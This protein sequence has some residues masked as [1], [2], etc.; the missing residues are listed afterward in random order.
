MQ[1]HCLGTAGYHPNED[2]H[3]SCYF[4]PESGIVLDAGTGMFRLPALI[5]TPSLDIL[6]SH[7]H[8]D[9]IA[10]LTFLLDIL[11]QHPVQTVRIW[12]EAK[13]LSAIREHLFSE[14][15]FPVQ[16]DVQWCEIDELP[17]FDL[18]DCTVS[19]QRQ[20]HPG[21]SVG[22]RLDFSRRQQSGGVTPERLRLLY[23]TDTT[24]RTDQEMMHWCSEADLMMHECYFPTD[25]SQWAIR[26]GHSWTDRVAEIAAATRP[27]LLLLTHVNPLDPD[28][29]ALRRQVE[30]ALHADPIPTR[31]AEDRMKL[32]FG[33]GNG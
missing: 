9:H 24:G 10:G 23:L 19:W 17:Q 4:L 8:L 22:Y 16:L 31:L 33:V 28:P 6:L 21:G 29:G 15:V 7:A 12:G 13:K 2:R 3:T 11:H 1:L 14:L 30:K 27:A 20:E 5:Q 26:T 18:G 25:K 32:S